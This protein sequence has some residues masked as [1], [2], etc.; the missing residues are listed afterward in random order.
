MDKLKVDTIYGIY[1]I[2]FLQK[3]KTMRFDFEAY[4]KVYPDTPA[5][6]VQVES[7]VDTFKPTESEK[8][9]DNKPG[10]EL[11]ATAPEAPKQDEANTTVTIDD[12]GQSPEG[13]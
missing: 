5:E 2:Y 8:V 13:V 12:L 7:A 1:L 3:G 10:E 6:P 4:Q 9:T 11:K